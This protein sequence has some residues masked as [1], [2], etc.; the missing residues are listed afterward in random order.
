MTQAGLVR[1]SA[2]QDSVALLALARDLRTSV[3]VRE[4]A[5]LMGTPA[6]H[7]VL[8][9]SGLL[10]AEAERAGP[11]DLVIVVDA[12]SESLALAALARAEELLT[13]TERRLH[14]AGR[15]LPRTM[16]SAHRQLPGANLALIS[17][18]GAWA[19]AE[20]RKALRLGLHVMLFSDHVSVEDEVALKRLARD[21]GLLLMGP[22]CG[23]AY[24][25]GA[26]LGFANAVPRGRIGLVAASG[27]G[28][29]QVACL[30]A[31]GGEG[32]SQA[33]G[34]GGR[35][36]SHAVG[37]L[38]TLG[39]L[40]ALGGDAETE[41]VIV[42]GKPPSPEIRR[43]VEDKL[44]GFGKP[45]VVALLGGEVG[46]SAGE[47]RVQMVATLEDAAEAALA[48]LR[49]ERWTARPFSGDRAAIRRR[50]AEAR[51]TL[52]PGQRSVHGLYA[53]GTLAYE[54][55]LLLEPLLGP[56]S[57]N[58]RHDVDSVHRIVDLGADE[59]TL[60]HAH[61]MIDPTSRI[62]AMVALAKDPRVAVLLLDVVLGHGAA[63][64]PAGDLLP[65]LRAARERARQDGRA[66]HVV[67]SVIGT[68]GDP[69]G[70]AA[71]V[72]TLESAGAW[73]LPSNAQAARAAAAIANPAP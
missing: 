62:D 42:I 25:S 9:Q 10:T 45:A 47:K 27:T 38:M 57:G 54:A 36:M 40:D 37:G 30:L 8:R 14:A 29:Q 64:D 70:L 35:D 34:V 51:R 60:G 28:L 1:K 11:N 73:V 48:A 55:L 24:L 59:F 3:G 2:Y 4:V 44:R 53:G 22:D 49:H 18:P 46:V 63:A 61:P 26:P 41:L 67:A 58:L 15:L 16:E 12:D 68:E 52:A 50:I 20:A 43:Q 66:L 65:A 6:N 21:K 19:A 39:A 69:Q 5:A 71:Q 13:A 56:V 23:T 7:D 33:I 31:A 17:V 72:A 32:I